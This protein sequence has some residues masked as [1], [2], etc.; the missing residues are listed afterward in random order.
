[1][2]YGERDGAD[3]ENRTVHVNTIREQ[4]ADFRHVTADGSTYVFTA[5]LQTVTDS[6][7]TCW[8]HHLPPKKKKSVNAVLGDDRSLW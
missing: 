5:V 3:C 7:P 2:L 8:N 1:M 6:V 4:N